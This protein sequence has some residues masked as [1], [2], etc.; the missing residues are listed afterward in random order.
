MQALRDR[1]RTAQA[2]LRSWGDY[3]PSSL[4]L[5][6]SNT[7]GM[8]VLGLC[9]GPGVPR[10]WSAASPRSRRPG[11]R[12]LDRRRPRRGRSYRFRDPDGHRFELNRTCERYEL[13]DDR[14]PAH[15]VVPARGI[16]I[17]RLDHDNVLAADVPANCDLCDALT[18][19]LYLRIELND[20]SEA[21]VWMSATIAAHELSYTRDA[22]GADGRLHH[23]A[24]WVDTR[25]ECVRA[26]D[27]WVD[28][29]IE[30]EAA[31]SKHAIAP[32]ASSC[33]ASSP[34]ATASRSP[35]G[36]ASSSRPTSRASSGRRL[37]A[38]RAGVGC[39]DGGVLPHLRHAARRPARLNARQ[40]G[41]RRG[42]A[43][44]GVAH[45]GA[46]PRHGWRDS[47]VVCRRTPAPLAKLVPAPHSTPG[48]RRPDERDDI[49]L[50]VRPRGDC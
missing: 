3:Q 38:P 28:H 33:T 31:P 25:E 14:R 20:G 8:G 44:P 34:A 19:R 30:I 49:A 45:A 23:L 2:T 27:I 18:Y 47:V 46:L 9:R 5:I 42:D 41:R 35:P 12:G 26:A 22:H 48:L 50:R 39:Q 1:A 37:S 15:K 32:R 43:S 4:K 36:G 7:S 11:W 16:A 40:A 17:K 21:G 13:P 29:G 6:A 24:F 10:R